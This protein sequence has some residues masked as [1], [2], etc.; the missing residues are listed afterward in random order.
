V[1]GRLR[2]LLLPQ[3]QRPLSAQALHALCLTDV[4][5]CLPPDDRAR[6][7]RA[8]APYLKACCPATR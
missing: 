7:A 2:C 5:L 1:W 3:S 4:E 8:L 6:F